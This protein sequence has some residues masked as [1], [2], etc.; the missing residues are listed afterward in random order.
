MSDTDSGAVESAPVETATTVAD[1]ESET[2]T[3]SE[4]PFKEIVLD[5]QEAADKFIKDRVARAQ[6][7]AEKKTQQQI[8]DL[9]AKLKS[10]EDA[11][12]S[13]SEKLVNAAKAAQQLADDRGN[14][15][16]K[17]QRTIKVGELAEAAKLPR[18]LWDRVRGDTD[19][20]LEAD[21]AKLATDFRVKDGVSTDS[22]PPVQSPNVS[23]TPTGGEIEIERNAKSIVDSMSFGAIRF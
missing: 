19:E 10:H 17:L 6:R 1:S 9:Q 16:T 4:S 5:S 8:D 11:K 23:V 15:L 22:R 18:S 7:S 13:D 14:E 20:E 2:V 3:P 21:I 12:L